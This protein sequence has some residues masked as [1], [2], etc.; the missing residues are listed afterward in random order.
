MISVDLR[1][2]LGRLDPTCASALQNAAGL[3]VAR[4]H[5]EVAVEHFFIK[6]LEAAASDFTLILAG[7]GV[8]R[9][10]LVQ[11]IQAALEELR[12]G[13]T[14]RPV[15]SPLLIDLLQDAWLIASIDLGC[16]QVRSG[17]VLLAF[18]ARPALFVTG[19]Y[20]AVFEGLG[21]EALAR[22]FAA[23]TQGSEEAEA[24]AEG[25]G[26]APE[27]GFLQ[28]FCQDFTARARAGQIDPVFGRDAEIRQMVDI[29]ARR[30]KNNP[31]CVGEPGVG[32]T[33]LVEGLA[34]RI[35]Q[36]DVPDLLK[37]ARLL[38]LDLALLEAG[39]GMKGEFENRLK[40]VIAELKASPA[41][42]VL[43]ID[44]AHTLNGAGGAAGGG[45]AAN[46]L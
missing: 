20:G 25:A 42:V 28:R 30:R 16:R 40:G 44:E 37:G 5:F 45:D 4:G 7:R 27:A 23:L 36:G 9:G 32:K 35:A 39:A 21:R 2:L 43:F 22:E 24:P 29:L 1:S 15:F 14:G 17:A 46:L 10:A 26:P 13:H 8:G 6:L 41:P 11:A 33:A 31:I 38:G 3:A 19:R 12:A 18:L 34:L